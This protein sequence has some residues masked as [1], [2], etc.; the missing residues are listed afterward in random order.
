MYESICN[1]LFSFCFSFSRANFVGPDCRVWLSPFFYRKK[2]K[3]I[4]LPPYHQLRQDAKRLLFSYDLYRSDLR[5]SVVG[6]CAW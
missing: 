1:R 2:V 4:L 5:S 3:K 6:T